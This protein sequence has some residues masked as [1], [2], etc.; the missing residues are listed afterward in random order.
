MVVPSITFTTPAR[1]IVTQIIPLPNPS[2]QSWQWRARIDGSDS[3]KCES[4]LT[5]PPHSTGQ[6]SLSFQSPSIQTCQGK[7]ILK[8][9]TTN[10]ELTFLLHGDS[11]SP[12]CDEVLNIMTQARSLTHHTV[13]LIN[14]CSSLLEYKVESD[15]PA[16]NGSSIVR[17]S[18]HS[19]TEYSFTIF[20][21]LSGIQPANLT[22]SAHYDG[23]VVTRWFAVKLHV[24]SPI[25]ESTVKLECCSHSSIAASMEIINPSQTENISFVVEIDGKNLLG[26]DE[27]FIEAGKSAIYELEYSPYKA[28]ES[29]GK[30]S[31]IHPQYGEYLYNL[32]LMAT[33]SPIIELAPMKAEIGNSFTQT[34]MI[35]NPTQETIKLKSQLNDTTA[36]TCQPSLV[37]IPPLGISPVTLI[38]SPTLLHTI[39]PCELIFSH[40]RAGDW[41]YKCSGQG[42]APLTDFAPVTLTSFCD[43][44]NEKSLTIKNP[45]NEEKEFTFEL[46]NNEN[47]TNTSNN[48]QSSKSSAWSIIDRPNDERKWSQ[49]IPARSSFAVNVCFIPQLI[50]TYYSTLLASV[51]NLNRPLQ[52]KFPLIGVGEGLIIIEHFNL[53]CPAR[54]S[55]IQRKSLTL[56]GLPVI[57][58][59]AVENFSVSVEADNDGSNDWL[60]RSLTVKLI[61]SSLASANEPI[62]VEFNFSPLRPLST[63]CAIVIKKQSGG[64][65]RFPLRLTATTPEADDE[66]L[67][68]ASVGSAQTINFSV[69]NLF[70]KAAK[71][72]AYLTTTSS[73]FFTIA[74]KTGRLPPSSASNGQLLTV[75]FA[76][77]EYGKEVYEATIMIET[78]EAV[79]KYDVKGRAPKYKIPKL[80]EGRVSQAIKNS[81]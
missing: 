61:N 6:F 72:K 52:W 64:S 3:F 42:L 4:V 53:N 16:I 12:Q 39:Q 22:F 38:Y 54:Q 7:L 59:D 24:A 77:L 75:T 49:I 19:T 56:T 28:E 50:T 17:V 57:N 81:Q 47:N 80:S 60:K 23:K 70:D 26:P 48:R 14:D 1:Q 67:L 44:P 33:D 31:F 73:P 66:I 20:P 79:M 65:W 45:F 15:L 8:N 32:A 30:I 51:N 63:Q 69:N 74:P 68:E 36:F 76:P 71:Y 62:I 34:F 27:L 35:A 21:L 9:R 58:S 41:R 11:Q 5:I 18:P 25:P 43:T 37:T 78:D 13:K 29:Q 40:P 10:D 55:L 2:L 46:I